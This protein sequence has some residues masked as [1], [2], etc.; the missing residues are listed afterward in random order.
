MT[1]TKANLYVL[2][3]RI[4]F[5]AF[6]VAKKNLKEGSTRRCPCEKDPKEVFEVYGPTNSVEEA[7]EV[8][9]LGIESRSI[10]KSIQ[11]EESK[12]V[13]AHQLTRSDLHYFRARY[14]YYRL[15]LLRLPPEERSVLEPVLA[16]FFGRIQKAE[17]ASSDLVDKPAPPFIHAVPALQ[18]TKEAI[19]TSS[20]NFQGDLHLPSALEREEAAR[21]LAQSEKPTAVSSNQS[22]L[23]EVVGQL[24]LVRLALTA[25]TTPEAKRI[26]CEGVD[27]TIAKLRSLKA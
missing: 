17:S 27:R 18:S 12:L 25:E 19:A 10:L 8:L 6:E 9:N 1:P 24:Q 11:T 16:R 21:M 4:F 2:Y 15:S 5:G 13:Q 7:A 20:M 23:D 22:L 3:I 14:H 26:L